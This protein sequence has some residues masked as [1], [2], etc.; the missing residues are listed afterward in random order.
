[1]N[2]S[3]LKISIITPSFNSGKFIEKAIKSVLAQKYPN[4]EHIIVDGDSTDGTIDILKKYNHLIWISETDKGQS[5]AMN[6]GFQM[7]TGDIIVYLNA[8]DHFAKNAFYEVANAF[9]TDESADVIVGNLIMMH[10]NGTIVETGNNFKPEIC[11]MLR[12]WEHDS[13]PYN[14]VSY[15]YRRSVQEKISFEQSLRFS[16]DYQFLL[17]V[18]RY[19]FK[20][21]KINVILGTFYLR[22]GCKTFDS[23]DN[24]RV[25]AENFNFAK[26]YWDL[27]PSKSL[28]VEHYYHIYFPYISIR[29]FLH[30]IKHKNF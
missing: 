1:M 10:D 11:R 13:Y 14:P 7:S 23:P 8:D 30:L 22:K 6:K 19:K 24:W 9:K 29:G 2:S 16:M 4:F 5:D 28:I 20:I 17:D 12:W 15:F 26:K 25:R 3:Y 18:C 21:K 27:C